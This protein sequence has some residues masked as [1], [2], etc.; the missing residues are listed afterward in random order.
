[1]ILLL[2]FLVLHHLLAKV[3]KGTFCAFRHCRI[4]VKLP[5]PLVHIS[6]LQPG[7][8]FDPLRRHAAWNP[9]STEGSSPNHHVSRTDNI[10]KSLG[11]EHR[12]RGQ[13]TS[14]PVIPTVE[15]FQS[16]AVILPSLRK[17][18]E[19]PNAQPA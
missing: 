8:M 5:Q 2:L 15:S 12:P 17:I 1:M 3:L 11:V 9:S 16:L 14:R 4:A 13:T 7:T 19:V 18:S 10:K 6:L